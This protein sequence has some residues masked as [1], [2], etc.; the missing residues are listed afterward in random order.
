MILDARHATAVL[1]R[2]SGSP[3][4]C[5]WKH[6]SMPASLLAPIV[7]TALRVRSMVMKR[8]PVALT[9]LAR[10]APGMS[11]PLTRYWPT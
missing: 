1:Y 9:S 4:C 6:A 11:A 2:P 5:H 7:F 10:Q 3:T 8:A